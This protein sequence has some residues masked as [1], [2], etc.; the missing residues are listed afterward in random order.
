MEKR[1]GTVRQATGD[2]IIRLIRL[3]CWITRLHKHRICQTY[4]FSTTKEVT[5]TRLNF[6]LCVHFVS[7]IQDECSITNHPFTTYNHAW[8]TD[9]RHVCLL[10]RIK[11]WCFHRSMK[12]WINTRFNSLNLYCLVSCWTQYITVICNVYHNLS[13][14]KYH[15]R[16]YSADWSDI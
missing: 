8:A 6:V 5:R 3:A 9:W 12:Y 13:V 1:C 10:P 4:C 15:V 14:Y 16:K 11:R 7:C 2:S